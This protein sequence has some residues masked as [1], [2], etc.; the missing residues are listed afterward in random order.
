[1]KDLTCA[2]CQQIDQVAKVSAI[3]SAGT[4]TGVQHSTGLGGGY[5]FAHRL[6]RSESGRHPDVAPQWTGHPST[7][8]SRRVPQE[9]SRVPPINR[10]ADSKMVEDR[11]EGDLCGF[12]KQLGARLPVPQA[13]Q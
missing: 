1:M 11:F 7:L 9:S 2:D 3:V 10:L 5:A 13:A 8:Y 6:S 4:Q 12:M